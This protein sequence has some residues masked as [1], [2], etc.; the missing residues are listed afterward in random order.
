MVPPEMCECQSTHVLRQC[1]HVSSTLLSTASLL[2]LHY[3]NLV[4]FLE[5]AFRK[6]QLGETGLSLGSRTVMTW[7]SFRRHT[8][9]QI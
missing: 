7:S 8:V 2:S 6:S 1:S 4:V 3:S 5:L 9:Y